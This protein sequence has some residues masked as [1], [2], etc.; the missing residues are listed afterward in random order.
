[1]HD[2]LQKRWLPRF[3]VIRKTWISGSILW[4]KEPTIHQLYYL[5]CKTFLYFLQYPFYCGKGGWTFIQCF[6]LDWFRLSL[7]V[8]Y[9]PSFLFHRFSFKCWFFKLHCKWFWIT[10]TSALFN[11][12]ISF[13][14]WQPLLPI[15]LQSPHYLSI[16]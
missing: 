2:Q 14:G 13:L 7:P 8:L 1:M 4:F 10:F 6:M 16:P 9:L 15:L 5:P 12:F 3:L 11:I